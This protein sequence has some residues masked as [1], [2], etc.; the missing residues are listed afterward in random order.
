MSVGSAFGAAGE[1]SSFRIPPDDLSAAEAA[2]VQCHPDIMAPAGKLS[3][4]CLGKT[5]LDQNSLA[6]EPLPAGGV[7]SRLGIK[8]K[9]EGV[10]DH[11]E[12]PLGLHE[13]AH[14]AE[15]ADR[16][17]IPGHEAGNDGVVG[18]LARGKGVIML[19]I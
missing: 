14:D 5:V 7:Q 15:G 16:A 8:A 4:N 10:H 19:G 2:A 11:L 9:V 18:A 3:G 6:L 17:A 1:D 12:V 13:P